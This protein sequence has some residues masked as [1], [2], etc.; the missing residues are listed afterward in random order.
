MEQ[1]IEQIP[2]RIEQAAVGAE[3]IGSDI[4]TD[5]F[6]HHWNGHARVARNTADDGINFSSGIKLRRQVQASDD[7][8][9][10]FDD[11]PKIASETNSCESLNTEQNYTLHSRPLV[12]AKP[13]NFC[14]MD[15]LS[16]IMGF[17]EIGASM[18]GRSSF[19]WG[20]TCK[21]Q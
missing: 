1:Y 6:E 10:G 4:V 14:G 2:L 17:L 21:P 16:W 13:A 3:H 19:A 5:A 7:I 8:G 12:P 9:F 11:A 18:E 20:N 15:W